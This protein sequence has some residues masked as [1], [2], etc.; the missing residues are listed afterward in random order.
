MYGSKF[1]SVARSGIQTRVC[2]I[3]ITCNKD[4]QLARSHEAKHLSLKLQ[5]LF[6]DKDLTRIG[7]VEHI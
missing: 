3:E 2:K 5:T 1:C 7:F 4:W 6:T